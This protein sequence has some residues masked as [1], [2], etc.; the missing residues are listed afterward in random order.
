MNYLLVNKQVKNAENDSDYL[1][2]ALVALKQMTYSGQV[3]GIG[4]A[5]GV[6]VKNPWGA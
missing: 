5:L 1:F 2:I 4:V 3:L 6:V